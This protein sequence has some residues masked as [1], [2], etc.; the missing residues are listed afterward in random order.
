MLKSSEHEEFLRH[1]RK[2]KRLFCGMGLE[3]TQRRSGV[4][5][6]ED[7]RVEAQFVISSTNTCVLVTKC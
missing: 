5:V 4:V 6:H 2:S 7:V 3:A 1:V